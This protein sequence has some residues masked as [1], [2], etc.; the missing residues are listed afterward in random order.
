MDS[1][2][3]QVRYPLSAQDEH[4][5]PTFMTDRI[6]EPRSRFGVPIPAWPPTMIGPS[7]FES[8]RWSELW[9]HPQ[10][11]AWFD[12][13]Q[14]LSVAALVRLE[15]RCHQSRPLAQTYSAELEQLRHDLGLQG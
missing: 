8:A 13:Q 11:L 3:A 5:D 9:N 6:P 12:K 1:E 7:E 2:T 14:D 4:P 10:A 15:Q